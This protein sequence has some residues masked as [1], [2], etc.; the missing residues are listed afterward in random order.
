MGGGKVTILDVN[1][2]SKAY[3]A[4]FSF[5]DLYMYSKDY[6]ILMRGRYSNFLLILFINLAIHSVL[7]TKLMKTTKISPPNLNY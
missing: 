2:W 7:K 4:V 3:S 5:L 6:N 1:V